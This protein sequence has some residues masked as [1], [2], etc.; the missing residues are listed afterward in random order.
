MCF[1]LTIHWEIAWNVAHVR[2]YQNRLFVFCCFNIN[3]KQSQRLFAPRF[4]EL[5]ASRQRRLRI[6]SSLILCFSRHILCFAETF[7]EWMGFSVSFNQKVLKHNGKQA[8]TWNLFKR[9]MCWPRAGRDKYFFVAAW[10]ARGMINYEVL[11]MLPDE[12]WHLSWLDGK[13]KYLVQ[14]EP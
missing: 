8:A 4:R 14:D 11:R 9:R 13:R 1:H 6:S 10:Q 7:R 3:T 5:K 2:N 12:M